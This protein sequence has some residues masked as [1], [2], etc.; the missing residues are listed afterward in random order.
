[1]PISRKQFLQQQKEQSN[2]VSHNQGLPTEMLNVPKEDEIVEVPEEGFVEEILLTPPVSKR[3]VQISSNPTQSEI[4]MMQRALAQT[5][6]LGQSERQQQIDTSWEPR[7][8]PPPLPEDYNTQYASQVQVVQSQ[9]VQQTPQQPQIPPPPQQPDFDN[10]NEPL[11]IINLTSQALFFTNLYGPETEN[12]DCTLGTVDD[13]D[14]TMTFSPYLTIPANKKSI[15]LQHEFFRKYL[16][17]GY[18]KAVSHEQYKNFAHNYNVMLNNSIERKKMIE[19]ISEQQG[20]GMIHMENTSSGPNYAQQQR[21]NNALYQQAMQAQGPLGTEVI[22][23]M[24]TGQE[25][26]NPYDVNQQQLTQNQTGI[27]VNPE[28]SWGSLYD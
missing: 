23:V 12:R 1:M 7:V 5:I 3:D 18:I 8:D 14:P 9:P 21:N 26:V 6:S 16:E 22:N 20:G 2:V 25:L 27:N 19:Q 17:R 28:T 24:G 11:Y 13:R 10:P 4:Q 15:A